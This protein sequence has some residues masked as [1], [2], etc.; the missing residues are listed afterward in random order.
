MGTEHRQSAGFPHPHLQPVTR[1]SCKHCCRWNYAQQDP[2]TVFAG[3]VLI[4]PFVD[5]PTLVSTDSF[6]VTVLVL[7]LLAKC[8]ALF[9]Y[10]RSFVRDKTFVN[11]RPHRMLCPG[12]RSRRKQILSYACS[13]QGVLRHFLATQDYCVS[14]C[15]LWNIF[16]RF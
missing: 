16:K 9:H 5:V 6:A 12:G 2:S 11:E 14:A 10:F 8:P 3:H 13:C 7:G 4:A 1:H 15:S